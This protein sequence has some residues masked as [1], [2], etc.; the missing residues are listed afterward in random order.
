MSLADLAKRL[1][2]FE[3]HLTRLRV[4]KGF[5]REIQANCD[6]GVWLERLQ[7]LVQDAHRIKQKAEALGDDRTALAAVGE[8][9]R[10]VEL[11]AKLT[12]QLEEKTQMNVVRVELSPEAAERIAETYLARHRTL[13]PS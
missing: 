12:G 3:N 4:G 1:Q 6:I 11:S 7:A 9:R 10:I 13:E 8:L 5:A 2:R